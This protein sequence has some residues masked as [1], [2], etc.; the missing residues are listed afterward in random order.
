M[1]TEAP[2]HAV[3]PRTD[4]RGMIRR[5]GLF[6][7]ALL[8][9]GVALGVLVST[10]IAPMYSST[11]GVLVTATGLPTSASGK[12]LART[13]A[14]LNLETESRVMLSQTVVTQAAALAKDRRPFSEL[15]K[16]VSVSVPPNTTVLEVTVQDA[17]PAVAQN[18][19]HAF[20]QAYL[21]NRT[22][23][24][25]GD[26][27]ADVKALKSQLSALNKQ[28][29]EAIGPAASLPANS[30][31]RTYAEAQQRIL[32]DQI[33]SVSDVMN[34]LTSTEINGGSILSD[35]STPVGPGLPLRPLI[36]LGGA[37]LGLVAGGALMFQL[38]RR[39]R[40]VRRP[41][42]VEDFADVPVIGR[43][44]SRGRRSRAGGRGMIDSWTSLRHDVEAAL[45]DGPAVLLT[46]PVGTGDLSAYAIASLAVSFG[47]TGLRVGVVCG[48]L[49]NPMLAQ[50]LG[51]QTRDGLAQ[52]LL[53][54]GAVDPQLT[55]SPTQDGVWVLATGDA[56]G[57]AG[58]LLHGRRFVEIVQALKERYDL[59]VIQ[60]LPA[61][62]VALARVA[63]RSL[64]L[65][66]IGSSRSDDVGAVAAQLRSRGTP[67]I[68]AVVFDNDS[69][70]AQASAA[71]SVEHGTNPLW[72]TAGVEGDP[73]VAAVPSGRSGGSDQKSPEPLIRAVGR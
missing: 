3:S 52:V 14:P 9:V 20:A 26:V 69:L 41:E 73:T 38:E 28:L 11:T 45:P 64:L 42:D 22:K 12:S 57:G 47:R 35:A 49:D 24:A 71:D 21:T 59:L 31:D 60:A 62:A 29:N 50:M 39:D 30:A 61:E 37:L 68:G 13:E 19:V 23:T 53:A 15:I 54:T 17:S 2:P 70:A 18:L 72:R 43:G 65:V 7:V 56:T 44:A 32:T 27:D 16:A 55:R 8:L 5:R 66:E 58:D 46:V 67:V 6:G 4:F 63:D 48:D 1:E 25:Q 40:L 33:S 34:G 51:V 36:V 10:R